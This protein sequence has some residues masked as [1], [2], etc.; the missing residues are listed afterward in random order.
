MEKQYVQ[1][2][3]ESLKQGVMQ[4]FPGRADIAIL[5]F[6]GSYAQAWSTY[7]RML[8]VDEVELARL[9]APLFQLQLALK[10]DG[11]QSSA[12]ALIPYAFC[13]SQNILPLLLDKKVLVVATA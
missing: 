2:P 6:D 10:L 5:Q 4:A 12:L 7:S 9:L 8:G 11:V 1:S 3:V 13:Q